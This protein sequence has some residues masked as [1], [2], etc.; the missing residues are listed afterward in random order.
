M[1]KELNLANAKNIDFAQ[2]AMS[3][4]TFKRKAGG[5]FTAYSVTMSEQLEAKI[6]AIA[7][8]SLGSLSEVEDYSLLAQPN[9]VSCL[10]LGQ[11]ETNL[12][13]LLNIV[14]QP[15]EENIIKDL[16]NIQNSIGYVVRFWSV[17]G[18]FYAFKKVGADWVTKKKTGFINA[19][20]KAN[21]LELIEDPSLVIYN[22]FDFYAVDEAILVANKAA[23]ESVLSYKIQYQSSFAELQKNAIFVNTFVD[24]APLIAHVGTNTMHLRRMA[25][26][27]QKAH[28]ADP[29]YMAR[30]RSISAQRGWKLAFDAAGKIVVTEESL[31]DIMQV[32]LNHRLYSELSLDSWDVP[33]ASQVA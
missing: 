9:E 20:L 11:D 31:R 23:F 7:V 29:L 30:L 17:A 28:F 33:S 25:V 24:M 14:S 22:R 4:W 19:V 1:T 16:K 6:R 15:A 10:H 27:E 13:V 21:Q 3:L 8:S 2:A 12:D 32:L 26:I 18:S 5:G